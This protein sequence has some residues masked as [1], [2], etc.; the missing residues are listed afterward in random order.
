MWA[1]QGV[2]SGTGPTSALWMGKASPLPWVCSQ[3]HP[4]WAR[5]GT[6][7]SVVTGP[8][9]A[10]ANQLKLPTLDHVGRR[11]P[12]PGLQVVALDPGAC[13]AEA[14]T[15]VWESP[16]CLLSPV[17][18]PWGQGGLSTECPTPFPRHGPAGQ[19]ASTGQVTRLPAPWSISGSLA[20]GPGTQLCRCFWS[21]WDFLP[22]VLTG[23]QNIEL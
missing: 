6:Q 19:T 18:C 13:A 8:W 17:P 3:H 5:G 21:E 14:V 16:T 15:L 4:V 20:P 12:R 22:S 23:V 2:G 1:G 9:A 7:D 11:L 10:G